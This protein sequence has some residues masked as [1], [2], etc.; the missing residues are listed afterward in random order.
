MKELLP[1]IP[2]EQSSEFFCYA[3]L[4]N[5]L[6]LLQSGLLPA[7]ACSEYQLLHHNLLSQIQAKSSNSMVLVFKVNDSL[8]RF[9]VSMTRGIA[10]VQ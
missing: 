10:V 3:G 7:G 1:K 9:I 4:I 6:K 5:A 2:A 8:F